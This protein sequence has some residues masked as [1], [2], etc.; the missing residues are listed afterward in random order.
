MS[1]VIQPSPLMFF[2]NPNNS[3]SPAAGFQLFWYQAGT[4]IKQNTW[5]DST[6]T[7]TNT[8]PIILD[9]NGSCVAWTDP[10][11]LYKWVLAGPNDTDP[12]SSPLRTVDN[13]SPPVQGSGAGFIGNYAS[14]TTAGNAL[15]TATPASLTSVSLTA[16]D[17]DVQATA[18]FQPQA[19]TSVTQFAV[20]PSATNNTFGAAGTYIQAPIAA[21]VPGAVS[22]IY[23]S[24]IQRFNLSS[25]TTIYCV[26]QA[27][28]TVSTCNAVGFIRA[29]QMH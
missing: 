18:Q 20:G 1:V 17:W 7:T 28:F 25:T 9:A 12:P 27:N 3:G 15:T 16:G 21:F 2:M 8:N 14:A 4:S 24:P 29:R 10:S 5:T 13:I 22:F 23:A 19:S 6:Q 26:G 11:L